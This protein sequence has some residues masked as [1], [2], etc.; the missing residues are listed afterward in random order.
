MET[1]FDYLRAHAAELGA[2]ILETYPPL[3]STKDPIAPE[4]ATL[5][6]KALPAQGLAITGTAKYLR[7]AKAARIVAE[8]GAGKTFMALGT[9]HVLTAGQPSTTL[10]MC[11]SH[12]THKWAREVLLTIP[13]ARAFLIEDMRNG[14][15]PKKQHGICEV[16]LSKGRT[17]YEGKHLTLAEMR[18]MGRREWR[19]RFSGPVFFIIGKD[20]GTLGYFWDHAYLKAKSGPNLGS[21]VNPDSGLAILDSEREKLTHLDFDDKVKVSETLISPKLGTTRFS[22]LWQADRTRIQRMAPIEYI[23]HYMR[24]WFDFAIAD[25]LH[26]L[27]GDTAQGNG[28]GVMGRASQ[29]LIALT[30]TLMG[31]YADD[32]FNIFFRMEPRVMVAEGFAYGGKGGAIFR[33]ST[34]F[35]KPSRRSRRLTTPVRGRPRRRSTYSASLERR[36][37]SSASS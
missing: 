9:I 19:K 3:Q 35:S 31:G 36:R 7:Q 8:C 32:L 24:G 1:T 12:I 10:V 34:A 22:A 33:S 20:K 17:V 6:R 5:L 30:G 15:D 28:L 26:Q 11:P 2:R 23:G 21:I 16:K 25:E 13:R 27:A 29:R 18:R 14:G 4:V 37:C